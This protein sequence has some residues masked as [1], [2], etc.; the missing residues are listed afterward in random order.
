MINNDNFFGTLR[1]TFNAL[2]IAHTQVCHTQVS[3]RLN[4]VYQQG[5]GTLSG[6][7]NLSDMVISDAGLQAI[8]SGRQK[9]TTKQTHALD[10]LTYDIQVHSR[11]PVHHQGSFFDTHNDVHIHCTG[12]A[13]ALKLRGQITTTAGSI[14]FPYRSLR[15]HSGRVHLGT[16]HEPLIELSASGDVRGHAVTVSLHGALADPTLMVWSPGLSYDQIIALLITGSP[17]ASVL[18]VASG[19]VA[20]ACI[21]ALKNQALTYGQVA[22]LAEH[23]GLSGWLGG[24]RWS[25]RLILTEDQRVGGAVDLEISDTLRATLHKDFDTQSGVGVE[26]EYELADG[27]QV[28]AKSNEQGQVSGQLEMRWKF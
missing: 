11:N 23:Q 13:G 6:V 18:H 2:E 16:Q 22:F 19:A 7:V 15:V 20:H 10:T 21:Q 27:V 3:G 8:R 5:E 14:L 24:M 17:E 12:K 26:L 4:L 25:P 28:I 9:N 1:A